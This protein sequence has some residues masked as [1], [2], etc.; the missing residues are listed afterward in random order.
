MDVDTLKKVNSLAKSLQEQG[1]AA[2]NEDAMRLASGMVGNDEAGDFAKQA[3]EQMQVKPEPEDTPQVTSE[4]GQEMLSE[5]EYQED[6]TPEPEKQSAGLETDLNKLKEKIQ[7]N[8]TQSSNNFNFIKQIGNEID[9]IYE[10]LNA[11][12]TTVRNM[13]QE[14]AQRSQQTEQAQPQ[15]AQ[16][17]EQPK[18]EQKQESN[19]SGDLTPENID[20]R[21][22]FYSG[23]GK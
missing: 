3:S 20:I 8:E 23:T 4:P 9:K 7:N 10:K 22:Y 13:R 1:L 5:P 18:Q 17:Q 6:T 12:S 14:S 15:Q 21:N 19:N 2:S 11:L 16:Q